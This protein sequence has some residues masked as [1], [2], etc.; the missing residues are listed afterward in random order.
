MVRAGTERTSMSLNE[1]EPSECRSKTT[2]YECST[3]SMAAMVPAYTPW[4]SSGRL[5]WASTRCPMLSVSGISCGSSLSSSSI[6]QL[7]L[8]VNCRCCTRRILRRLSSSM[9]LSS[10]K[11]ASEQ[12]RGLPIRR[13]MT[14]HSLRLSVRDLRRGND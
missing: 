13:R 10:T 3:R 11:K 5:T 9:R 6:E 8:R 4:S 1:R 14:H 2:R 12:R 7:L